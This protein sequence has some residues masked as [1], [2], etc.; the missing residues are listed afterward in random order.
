MHLI[1]MYGLS[2]V[3]DT[4]LYGEIDKKMN[5]ILDILHKNNC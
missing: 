2:D 5:V 1:Y 3:T 4:L